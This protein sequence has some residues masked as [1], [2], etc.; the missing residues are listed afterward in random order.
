V[1]GEHPSCGGCLV[2]NWRSAHRLKKSP[3]GQEWEVGKIEREHP[4]LG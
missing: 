3:F 2:D 1:R 4:S